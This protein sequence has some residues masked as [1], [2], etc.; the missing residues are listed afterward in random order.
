[1]NRWF[2]LYRHARCDVVIFSQSFEDMDKKLRI[3]ANR[4][5]LVERSLI[6]KCIRVR[7]ISKR[8]YINE[9]DKQI[10]DAYD[11]VPFTR[12]IYFGPRYWK[13]FDSYIMPAYPAKQWNVF[14]NSTPTAFQDCSQQQTKKLMSSSTTKITEKIRQ[15]IQRW[16]TA[17]RQSIVQIYYKI[18][19]SKV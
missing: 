9:V 8:I 3:L 7:R 10:I 1:M 11:F 18:F 2:K 4:Y 17:V 14:G 6:P 12:R 16:S 19:T 15:Q 13:H 5:F